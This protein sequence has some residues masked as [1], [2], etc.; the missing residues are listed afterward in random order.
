MIL[1]IIKVIYLIIKLELLKIILN[2]IMIKRK[3][4]KDIKTLIKRLGRNNFIKNL[5]NYYF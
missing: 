5:K 4:K 3:K 1:E 2:I